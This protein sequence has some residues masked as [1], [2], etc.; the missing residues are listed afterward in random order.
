MWNIFKVNNKDTP[1][2]RQGRSNIIVEA[3]KKKKTSLSVGNALWTT[4]SDFRNH[5]TNKNYQSKLA[6]VPGKQ[7]YSNTVNLS[8]N[9]SNILIFTVSIAKGIL[10]FELISLSKKAKQRCWFLP[11]HHPTKWSIILMYTLQADRSIHLSF[12]LELVI[13]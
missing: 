11:V 5:L 1:E 9:L 8:P 7:N 6:V 3:K 2:W 12:T 10:I 4:S 13:F